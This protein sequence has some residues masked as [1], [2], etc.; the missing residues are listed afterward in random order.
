MFYMKCGNQ[1]NETAV[2]C[3]KCGTPTGIKETSIANSSADGN[4]ITY[5]N[6][7]AETETL[8]LD[9]MNSIPVMQKIKENENEIEEITKQKER[10]EKLLGKNLGIVGKVV[11]GYFVL[12]IICVPLV[13]MGGS[14]SNGNPAPGIIGT[15]F[16][17]AILV[18]GIIGYN[19]FKKKI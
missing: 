13:L 16:G 2:F 8:F 19:I 12:M 11:R 7:E 5:T 10:A 18:G 6:S 17:A 1:L 9:M 3:D 15:I 14:W 4:S